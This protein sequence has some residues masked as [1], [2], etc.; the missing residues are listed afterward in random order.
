MNEPTNLECINFRIVKLR[1]TSRR[2]ENGVVYQ[3]KARFF[4]PDP[5]EAALFDSV[6]EV[7]QD[8][9]SDAKKIISAKP[10]ALNFNYE[11]AEYSE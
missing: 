11:F 7:M 8:G 4:V 10:I 3:S 5:A 9:T 6:M 2:T 1:I